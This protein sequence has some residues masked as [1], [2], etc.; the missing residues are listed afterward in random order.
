VKR[1]KQYLEAEKKIDRQKAYPLADSIKLLKEASYA[2]FDQTVEMAINLNILQKHTVRDT[3]VLP[4]GT[5]KKVSVLVFAKADKAKEAQDAGADFVGDDDLVEK[6]KGGWFDFDVAVATPDMMKSVG[7]IGQLLG[8]RGLM[9][10]PKTGTVTNDI[11]RTVG[12]LK[13]GRIEFRAD[14]SGIIHLGIGKMSMEDNSLVEN[15]KALYEGVLHKRPSDLK[16]EYI[17]SMYVS[18]TMSPGIKIDYKQIA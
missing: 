5:G 10:N 13:K 1:G 8:K 17:K 16:G 3:V 11:K 6:I 2:K 4:F 14:K 9:P 12:E 7:K 18:A 15:I